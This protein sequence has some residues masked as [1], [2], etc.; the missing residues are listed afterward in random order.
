MTITFP[1][2]EL[3][4]KDVLNTHHESKYNYWYVVK[5]I[6]QCG[7]SVLAQLLLIYASFTQGGSVSLCVSPVVSQSRK[8]FED[9]LRIADKLVVKSNGSTLEI[10]FVNGSRILFRSAEQ[11]DAIRG[12]T[13]KGSGILVVDEAAYIKDELFYS[14]LV[15][16][17]NVNKNAIFIFSTPKFKTG[18]FY[19]LYTKGLN[20]DENSDKNNL[21]VYDWTKYDLSKYL[22]DNMLEMYRSQMPKLSFA[23]EFLGEFIDADGSVFTDFK[24]NIK[25]TKIDYKQPV[26]MAIDWGTGTGNDNT[27]ITIGQVQDNKICVIDQ[28][29][30]N[31]KN[32]N[33]TIDHIES[34]VKGLLN[35]GVKEVNILCEKNSIGNVFYQLMIDKL[36]DLE[37]LKNETAE[38]G[39]EI[40]INCNT[41]TTTNKSKEE[42]IKN[43]I[44]CIE[45]NKIYLPDIEQ[46]ILEMSAYECRPSKTGLL[47]YNAPSGHHDDCVM[48]LCMLVGRLFREL[49]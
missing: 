5:S 34:M 17:T 1:E 6:R 18:F 49:E 44:V 42:I 23:S 43:T 4:Q 8:M 30:F 20:S 46:L 16:T 7:K 35:R 13:V 12:I 27:A 2:L 26:Y 28:V 10:S 3:W 21:R 11:G 48:S 47:T 33:Q 39:E 25:N 14:V 15:P 36:D 37:Q 38:Y 40:E 29:A 22:P 41:F 24:K 32:A 9:I 31:D 19:E 45:Q